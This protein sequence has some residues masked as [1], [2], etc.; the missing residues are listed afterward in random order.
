MGK[1]NL[2]RWENRGL[3]AMIVS[4]DQQLE[5]NIDLWTPSSFTD[6]TTFCTL[7]LKVSYW[8]SRARYSTFTS[9]QHRQA[10]SAALSLN[11]FLIISLVS[12]LFWLHSSASQPA[13]GFSYE[14]RLIVIGGREKRS[15][16]NELSVT[17]SCK[18]KSIN[19]FA[20]CWT[21]I[22]IRA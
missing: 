5:T 17:W 14:Y 7:I 19:E 6:A 4:I 8:E 2:T 22:F 10:A 18:K 16:Q 3:F 13:N 20:K 11:E 21:E 12:S 15:E 9:F 1:T